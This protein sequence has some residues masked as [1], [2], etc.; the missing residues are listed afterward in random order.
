MNL[1]EITE[2]EELKSCWVRFEEKQGRDAT[3]EESLGFLQSVRERVEELFEVSDD[4]VWKEIWEYASTLSDAVRTFADEIKIRCMHCGGSFYYTEGGVPVHIEGWPEVEEDKPRRRVRRKIGRNDPCPCGSENKYKN[5]CGDPTHEVEEGRTFLYPLT[6]RQRC[7]IERFEKK[8]SKS[9]TVREKI[10]VLEEAFRKD[11]PEFFYGAMNLRVKL[12][13]I[14]DSL[15]DYRRYGDYCRFLEKV[16]EK[17]ATVF[18]LNLPANARDL[19]HWYLRKEQ[20]ENA[21]KIADRLS[22]DPEPEMPKVLDLIETL[23]LNGVSEPARRLAVSH[24]PYAK[25]VD[26]EEAHDLAEYTTILTVTDHV[27]GSEGNIDREKLKGELLDLGNSAEHLS[28][29][30]DALIRPEKKESWS[31]KDLSDGIDEERARDLRFGYIA[32]L[33]RNR[34]EPAPTCLSAY[35]SNAIVS[36]LRLHGVEALPKLEVGGIAE[37][38]ERL[39]QPGFSRVSRAL[40]ELAS[41][42]RFVDFLRTSQIIDKR[43]QEHVEKTVKRALK[44]F[45]TKKWKER[46]ALGFEER[47]APE[48]SI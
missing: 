42:V 10:S 25:I 15:M 41:V 1:S 28:P 35:Y 32:Y 33:R 2:D 8:F 23:A 22:D 45:K 16:M 29:Y 7:K 13:D 27:T 46:Y 5:C 47:L 36:H 43:E 39:T 14:R 40:A 12:E 24:L 26:S 11:E 31:R 20:S 9:T 38:V 37:R 18:D 3:Y 48:L 6:Q 17:H 21:S 4:F 34:I 30:L 19:V 44:R